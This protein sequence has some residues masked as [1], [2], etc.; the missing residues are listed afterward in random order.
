MS[1]EDSVMDDVKPY[2]GDDTAETK[3]EQITSMFNKIAPKYDYLNRTLSFGID[4]VWRREVVKRISSLNGKVI[5]DVA[6]GTGDLALA[7]AGA[8]PEKIYGLDISVNM[9]DIAKVKVKEKGLQETINFV[10]GDSEA[11]PFESSY[12]DVVTVAFGVR[13]F[14]SLNKGLKEMQ[15]VLK[16]DGRLIVL[17]FSKPTLFPVKQFYN[18][19]FS[20]ILPWWG[21]II[22]RDRKA[23][24][25]LPQSVKSFCEGDEFTAELKKA[26]FSNAIQKRLTFGIASIYEAQ[27]RSQ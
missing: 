20:Y 24:E 6:T 16:P 9:L 18:L 13:N 22:S 11:L 2:I 4:R 7:V 5:L 25:Y 3:K 26:G 15:R 19:Y 8:A 17:E 1:T 10:E 14:E 12:F 23:Y 21:G 27:K